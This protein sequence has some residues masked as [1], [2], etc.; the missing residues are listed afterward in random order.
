MTRVRAR[1]TVPELLLR[2]ELHARGR[3]YRLQGKLP[4]RPDIVFSSAHLAVFVD[5]DMWHGHGWR[6]RG[7]TSMEAQFAGHR[8]PAKWVAKIRRNMER[9]AEA[10]A[11]LANLGWTVLRLLESEI[12]RDVSAAADQVEAYLDRGA[13]GT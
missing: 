6:E 10:N 8:D 2:R 13:P 7:F 12:R 4:G 5:G 1:D 9:D 11:A 3:R